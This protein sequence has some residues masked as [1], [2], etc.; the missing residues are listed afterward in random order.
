LNETY[1]TENLNQNQII[2]Q[3]QNEL[4][5]LT[6]QNESLNEDL[7][8]V[9][10]DIYMLK[11]NMIQTESL[12]K[13]CQNKLAEKSAE[14]NDLEDRLGRVQ[15]DLKAHQQ[16][17]QYT[18]DEINSRENKIIQLEY[19]IEETSNQLQLVRLQNQELTSSNSNLKQDFDQLIEQ[20]RNAEK[21]LTR[22]ESVVSELQM[23]FTSTHQ[24]LKKEVSL[25][26]LKSYFVHF[27]N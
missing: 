21:E 9:N 5:R 2:Q 7:T 24:Q 8:Q 15:S 3:K 26:S 19:E 25:K 11:Q 22:M 17:Y 23:N 10:E 27:Y 1:K 18:A 13:T 20:K 6:Q 14:Y 4:K 12:Y 16:R